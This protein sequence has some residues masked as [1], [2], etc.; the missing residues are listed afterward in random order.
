MVEV[1]TSIRLVTDVVAE[2]NAASTEQSA[3]IEQVN[4]ANIQMDQVTQQM[5]HW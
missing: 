2:I 1:V 3:G 5:R 4:Q